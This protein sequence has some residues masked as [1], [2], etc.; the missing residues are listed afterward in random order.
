MD[1]DTE[2]TCSL[3]CMV[4]K[5]VGLCSYTMKLSQLSGCRFLTS[6]LTLQTLPTTVTYVMILQRP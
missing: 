2:D 1:L 6:I 5:S 3:V 4:L